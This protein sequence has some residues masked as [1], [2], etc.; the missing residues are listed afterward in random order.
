MNHSDP[1]VVSESHQDTA[2]V[3]SE[4]SA[5]DELNVVTTDEENS[6]TPRVASHSDDVTPTPP[7]STNRVAP[8]SHVRSPGS[9]PAAPPP[10]PPPAAPVGPSP[11][12]FSALDPPLRYRSLLDL[13]PG[14]AAYGHRMATGFHPL[15]F[16][17]LGTPMV[18][19][20]LPRGITPQSCSCCPGK[21]HA[22]PFPP[23]AF[24]PSPFSLQSSPVISG[25]V[26]SLGHSESQA[27]SVE[28]LRRKAQEYSAAVLKSLHAANLRTISRL[29]G[30]E[31]RISPPPP[32]GSSGYSIRDLVSPPDDPVSSPVDPVSSNEERALDGGGRRGEDTRHTEG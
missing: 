20:F 24:F 12:L 26:T 4:P 7:P 14:S 11:A 5:N 21:T 25:P 16:P 23:S 1:A 15:F 17:S 27:S 30:V 13:R 8:S 22:P 9:C 10:P 2:E 3:K 18:S 28:E 31:P 32:T 19:P 6:R 29:G